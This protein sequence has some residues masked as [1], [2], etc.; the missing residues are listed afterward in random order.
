MIVDVRYHNYPT[1]GSP[2]MSNA[3][4]NFVSGM[5][6]TIAEMIG[7]P[8]KPEAM[9]ITC[10]LYSNLYGNL[11][12]WDEKAPDGIRFTRDEVDAILGGNAARLLKLNN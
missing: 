12:M 11:A 5:Y 3:V 9:G 6:I 4:V 1:P 8:V 2:E 7:R 10:C